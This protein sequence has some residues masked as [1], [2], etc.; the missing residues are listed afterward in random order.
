TN[1]NTSSWI[2]KF[3][4]KIDPNTFAVITITSGGTTVATQTVRADFDGQ[5]QTSNGI[6]LGAGTYSAT[7][8]EYLSSGATTPIT[9]PS[10]PVIFSIW[11]TVSYVSAGV[12]ST[13]FLV[14]GGVMLEVLA[15]GTANATEVASGAVLQVDGD[16]SASATVIQSGG[17][18][19]IY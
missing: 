9:L 14:S 15:G 12:T 11:D 3:T 17:S 5:W 2:G 7:M 19:T 1:S 4:N 6:N 16:G 8:T 13:G 10:E 18:E